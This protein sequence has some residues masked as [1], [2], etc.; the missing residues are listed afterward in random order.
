MWQCYTAMVTAC[1]IT[2]EFNLFLSLPSKKRQAVL[3]RKVKRDYHNKTDENTEWL[4]KT[5]IDVLLFV[6][7]QSNV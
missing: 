1:Q 5:E 3:P 4:N 7:H 6:F 2:T